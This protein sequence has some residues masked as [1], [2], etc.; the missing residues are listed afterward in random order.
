MIR[1]LIAFA[2]KEVFYSKR[3]ALLNILKK[4]DFSNIEENQ[5]YQ[6]NKLSSVLDVAFSNIEYYKKF[7]FNTTDFSYSDFKKIPI[8]TKEII[9]TQT[10]NLINPSFAKLIEISK[11]SSGGSTGEPVTFFQTKDQKQHGIV[12][13][14]LALNSNAVNINDRSV[15]LWGA[16]QDM[17]NTDTV[18]NIRS[19]LHN[20]TTLNTFVLSDN[21]MK[22]YIRR[23][24]KIKPKF[25]KAYVHSIYDL[26][27]F[28]NKNN[29][30]INFKP[31]IQ[32]TT[33][34]LY[35]E[36][37]A[38]IEKAFNQAHLFNFYGSREVSAIATEITG[39]SDMHI[40]YDNV[41]IEV[42]DEKGESVKKGEEGEIVVTTLNNF[43]MP[44][45]RYKIGDRAVK[46]DNL[47][48]GTLKLKSVVG[49][50][51]GV[52]H[53]NDGSKI[54]G[55]FFTTL[56]FNKKGIKS[57]QLIQKTISKLELK[58]I[59]TESFKKEELNTILLRIE[60]ELPDVEIDVTYCDKINL[61]STGKIMY[62]YSR[63]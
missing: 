53:R 42:L 33:G 55:Q 19:I 45:I 41:L 28:I 51:L 23:L 36:M 40:L 58:I 48:F 44:L 43:Y 13:Y 10:D 31:V 56:F 1:K 30:K 26:S 52:I 12:N 27:K 62:V 63:L 20:N 39:N 8:L 50:T 4:R 7:K 6:M 17:H 61:T 57:F 21:I 5:K 29:I 47:E 24:N 59:K 32:C 49:R 34:P 25:I 2:Y 3:I 37:R 16:L 9:R 38:E 22:T 60:K 11:N 15:Y 35:P 18:F 46:G 14:F 54:D